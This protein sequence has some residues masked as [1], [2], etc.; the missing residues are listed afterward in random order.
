M[1]VGS[2]DPWIDMLRG[3]SIL[4]VLLHHFSIAYHLP[5]SPLGWLFT[6][7]A[8]RA[9]VRNGNYGVTMFF[10]ISGFLITSNA[11]RRWG[12]LSA[13]RASSF[14]RLRVARIAPCLLL[15][16][17]IVAILSACGL[18]MFQTGHAEN[19]APVSPWLVYA[20]AL[21]FWMNVLIVHYGWVNYALGVLW[22]L[23]VEEVFYLTFPLL[24]LLRRPAI[25]ATIWCV[26]ILAA[27]FWRAAHQDDLESYLYAFPAAADG[28]A[29]GCLAAMAA[30]RMGDARR[31]P[32]ALRLLAAVLMAI[33][34]LSAS[35]GR[36]NIWGVTAMAVGTAILLLPRGSRAGQGG[37]RT[38]WL[39]W[40]GRQSYELYLF[41]LVVLALLRS[42]WAPA[43]ANG[44][45]VMV[46]LGVYLV[47]CAL[48]AAAIA[49]FVAEPANAAIR[50]FGT[51]R[52][53]AA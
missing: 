33:L 36:T 5:Q 16:L 39:R 19:G 22:S 6:P 29:I 48:L 51:M 37:A 30:A 1:S 4:L 13:V 2:R 26:V 35:I 42:T 25:I 12:T 14:Y 44:T 3:V 28:I 9:V 20:A 47:L 24:C 40:L 27:P 31:I 52:I 17:A 50:R 8:V 49:R 11:L 32:G 23:S 45:A 46:L 38:G 7:D 18:R 43:Q 34:Y 53:V 21:G 41:H 15:L 10:V